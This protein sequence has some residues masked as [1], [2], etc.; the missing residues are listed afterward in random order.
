[1]REN[2][3]LGSTF[4]RSNLLFQIQHEI[5]GCLKN[6]F[7]TLSFVFFESHTFRRLLE[8]LYRSQ[9]PTRKSHTVLSHVMHKVKDFNIFDWKGNVV[10]FDIFGQKRL[11]IDA[12]C[13]FDLF[14]T[15]KII[16]PTLTESHHVS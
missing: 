8:K 9:N 10:I 4:S 3:R 14:C 13:T 12:L 15:E 5:S 11:L 6:D 1:M 16:H 7:Q 2:L